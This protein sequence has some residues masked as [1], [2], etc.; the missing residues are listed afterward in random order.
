MRECWPEGGLRAYLDYELPEEDQDRLAAHL[1]TCAECRG[2]YAELAGRAARVSRLIGMLPETAED[3]AVF[4]GNQLVERRTLLG[5]GSRWAP[6]GLALAAALAIAL[7]MLPSPGKEPVQAVAPAAKPQPAEPAP[8]AVRPA[9]IRGPAARRPMRRSPV[10]RADY[11]VALDDEPIETARVV[12]VS[13]ANSDVQADLI[14]GPDGQAH[15]IRL[16]SIK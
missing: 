12:R 14:V 8:A 7:V 2:R 1:E 15:A 16:V 10:V 6:V 3:T 11:Y 9:V 4:A 13:V 5:A